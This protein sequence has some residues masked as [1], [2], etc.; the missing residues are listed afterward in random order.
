MPI[1][2]SEE[3]DMPI[4]PNPACPLCG[5]RFGNKPLVDLHLWED[6][7]PCFPPR[8]KRAP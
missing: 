7:G 1:T 8:T 2:K 3:D 4:T 6:H 5:L